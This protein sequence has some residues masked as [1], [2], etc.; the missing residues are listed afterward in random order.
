MIFFTSSNNSCLMQIN[1]FVYLKETCIFNKVLYIILLLFFTSCL[2][3]ENEQ[4]DNS[5]NLKIE[6]RS[7][8]KATKNPNAIINEELYAEP[9]S[10]NNSDVNNQSYKS[11]NK[12]RLMAFEMSDND[13]DSLGLIF[14]PTAITI[15]AIKVVGDYAYFSDVAHSNIKKICLKTGNIQASKRIDKDRSFFL[16]EIAYFNESL[17]VTSH[18]NKIFILTLDLKYVDSFFI[19]ESHHNNLYLYSDRGEE[20]IVFSDG[21]NDFIVDEKTRPSEYVVDEKTK[22]FQR[23]LHIDNQHNFLYDTLSFKNHSEYREWITT[24]RGEKIEIDSTF[25]YKCNDIKYEVPKDFPE[26]EFFKGVFGRNI[27]CSNQ[28]LA[29][30]EISLEEKKLFLH[31]YEY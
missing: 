31:V 1:P 21:S 5:K 19:P 11:L 18:R 26:S 17:Y 15:E 14:A 16:H 3:G 12:K 4:N 27:D 13:P 22:I 8:D 9:S 6:V 2:S 29:F 28:Y 25:F 20:L 10:F 30:F 24:L 23:R 7:E